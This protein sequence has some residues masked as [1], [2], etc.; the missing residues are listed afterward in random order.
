MD[1]IPPDSPTNPRWDRPD[2]ARSGESQFSPSPDN[3]PLFVPKRIGVGWSPNLANPV[4]ARG[5]L[6]GLAGLVAIV[7]L[8][9]LV[10]LIVALMGHR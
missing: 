10:L 3:P 9:L 7:I 8:I 5:C 1:N 4:M 6:I 2:E